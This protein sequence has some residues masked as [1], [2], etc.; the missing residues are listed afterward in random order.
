MNINEAL[1]YIKDLN[2]LGSKPGLDAVKMLLY[3]LDNP[4]DKL[5]IIHIGGT[6]GKGSIG[7]YLDFGYR[8]CGLKVGRYI[9]P[10]LFSYLERF[11]INGQEMRE[12]EFC[13]ILSLIKE[14]CDEM[15]KEGFSQPTAFEVET[16]AAFI[17]FLRNNV[18]LVLLE[19]G[20]GGKMDA[21]NV[22]K[23][24]IAT[25]FASISLDHREYLGD[26]IEE[27][28]RMKAGIMRK[29]VPAIAS[30]MP[31]S[32]AKDT[33]KMCADE[34][35][36]PFFSIEDNI[37]I[38]DN[39]EKN[40]NRIY[41]KGQEI[42]NPLKGEFQEINLEAALFIFEVLNNIQNDE[43]DSIYDNS[44]F[45]QLNTEDF[46]RGIEKT[47][48]PGRYELMS[49]DP[50]VI[51]DGAHNP[52]AV[53]LL[54]KTIENDED[55][56]SVSADGTKKVH[57]IMGVFKDKDYK[58]MLRIILPVAASFSAIT[59]PNLSRALQA[60][61]LSDCAKK[62]YKEIDMKDDISFS[63]CDSLKEAI[64]STNA[65]ESE[66]IVVFGSLSLSNLFNSL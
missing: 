38:S 5:Q 49:Q 7:A 9:S 29:G 43:S 30:R 8:E 4:Q 65:K 18:D 40:N 39:I 2:S 53:R 32:V 23:S 56:I 3:K 63:Y 13:D 55:I 16:A 58:E 54:R 19:V 45:K 34:T 27:I 21:T 36:A 52:D 6:N 48:W 14:K 41:F 50:N 66:T 59:P 62:I 25:V 42:R 60:K 17:Y 20:M 37:T 51:R 31:F 15:V 64:E 12:D 46:I 11:Q 22:V 26:S 10:T 35:G 1:K 33:L 24:P 57:L 44:R 61:D 28:A 47:K